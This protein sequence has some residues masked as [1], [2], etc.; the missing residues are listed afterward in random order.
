M[1]GRSF[2]ATQGE[3]SSIQG[4]C[5]VLQKCSKGFISMSYDTLA[6]LVH[7]LVVEH[8]LVS[9]QADTNPISKV[10]SAI[11][12]IYQ[13]FLLSLYFPGDCNDMVR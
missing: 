13:L 12:C 8:P 6:R 9:S 7:D 10:A 3:I 2:V 11:L 1:R 5:Q 4:A